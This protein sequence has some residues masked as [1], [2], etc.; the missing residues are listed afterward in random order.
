MDKD[1]DAVLA[2]RA[3]KPPNKLF[4]PLAK[5]RET[6]EFIREGAKKPKRFYQELG[7]ADDPNKVIG[8]KKKLNKKNKQQTSNFVRELEEQADKPV[9]KNFKLSKVMCEELEYYIEK[10]SDDY[11]A[12]ARD[13]K[14][15]YQDSPGQ[16][17]Y[18]IRKYLK[19][20]K[21]VV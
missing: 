17:R 13:K 20:H 6:A 2:R 14:N 19:I 15:I 1:K 8:R 21:G 12:M 9:K 4:K 18:K 10:Y 7:I 16:L 3:K 5:S 11:Q